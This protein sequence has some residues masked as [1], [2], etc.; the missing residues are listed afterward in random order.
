MHVADLASNPDCRTLPSKPVRYD[1]TQLASQLADDTIAASQLTIDP[2]IEYRYHYGKPD[3]ACTIFQEFQNPPCSSL[4]KHPLNSSED[5]LE[6]SHADADEDE[7]V[8]D[9]HSDIHQATSAITRFQSI[10]V[11]L[12]VNIVFYNENNKTELDCLMSRIEAPCIDDFNFEIAVGKT[13]KQENFYYILL[14]MH[15]D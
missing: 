11:Q 12:T 15:H 10:L 4:G 7:E 9:S 1:R 3:K 2:T 6:D 13:Q 5:E 14:K 8:E